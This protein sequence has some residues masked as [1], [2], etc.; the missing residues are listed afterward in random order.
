M[1]GIISA[2]KDAGCQIRHWRWRVHER[3]PACVNEDN[4]QFY[5]SSPPSMGASCF[6]AIKILQGEEVPRYIDFRSLDQM[7]ITNGHRRVLAAQVGRSVFGP[8]F[9]R[10]ADAGGIPDSEQRQA[11]ARCPEDHISDTSGSSGIMTNQRTRSYR[12]ASISGSGQAW[13]TSNSP[14]GSAV[15][16]L[17]GENGAEINAD[18]NPR[19]S[20][21]LTWG[22]I[23]GRRASLS[24]KA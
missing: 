21:R 2:F 16:A 17:V 11:S 22:I 6:T 1:M 10:R 23:P 19:G 3:V 4:V 9:I 15:H 13:T 14:F 7:R 18:Q 8:V 5:Y 12:D 24:A 20:T